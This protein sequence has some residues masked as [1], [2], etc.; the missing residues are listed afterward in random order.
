MNSK[1]S[2][3]VGKNSGPERNIRAFV[4]NYTQPYF[5]STPDDAAISNIHAEVQRSIE[6]AT[7]VIT[8]EID[9][10]LMMRSQEVLAKIGWTLEEAC[11]LFYYWLAECPEE[12]AAWNKNFEESLQIITQRPLK[13]DLHAFSDYVKEYNLTPDQIT[14]EM[15][16]MFKL[17]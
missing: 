3:P 12:A 8:I 5:F 2:E 13:Y 7:D 1:I 11:V 15:W 10:S 17:E 14:D 16:E 6:E 9:L 4:S